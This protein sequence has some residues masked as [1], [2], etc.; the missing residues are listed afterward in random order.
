VI[1][2][3]KTPGTEDV[4][5]GESTK[6]ARKTCPEAI[7]PV[8]ARKLDMINYAAR[9]ED[10]QTPPGNELE[11]LRG[12]RKGQHSIRINRQFRVCFVWTGDGAT[13][14]EITDYH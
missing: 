13:D 1:R 14:V 3:F 11:K 6:A 7:W 5:S 8:A 12:D 4:F 9:L 2:S 10:L